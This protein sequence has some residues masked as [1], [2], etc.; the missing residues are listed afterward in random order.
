MDELLAPELVPAQ[1]AELVDT[2]SR[3]GDE[4]PD[5]ADLGQRLSFLA[6]T[7]VPDLLSAL[8]EDPD[9]LAFLLVTSVFEGLDHRLVRDETDRLLKLADG[10]LDA[11]FRPVDRDGDQGQGMRG[12]TPRPNPR[13]VF[14]RSLDELLETVRAEYLPSEVREAEGYTFTVEPVRFKRHR[15]AETVLRHVWRQYG[16]VSGLLTEWMD[17][18]PGTEPELARP[19][20]RVMGLAAGWSGGR[21][22]LRHIHEL[23]R[24][25]R[26]QSRRT[27]AYALGIAAQNEVLAGEV[28]YRLRSWSL[29]GG[30]RLRSTVA[31]ACGMDF[32]ASRPAFAISLLRHC[33]RGEEGDEQTVARAVE[34]ALTSLFAGGN[35]VAVFRHLME[36]ASRPG[37]DGE[38]AL[39]VFPHLLLDPSWFQQQLLTETEFTDAVIAFIRSALNDDGRY[40]RTSL[41]L[42]EWCHRALRD[43]TLQAAVES[44]LT[45]LA[46]GMRTGEFR[47]LVAV[48]GG[49]SE[50]VGRD[51][52]VWA[53]EAW[54]RGEPQPH[55]PAHTSEGLR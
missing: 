36:W 20:G 42:L 2:V 22:A 8:R 46:Q 34:W 7:E 32:G 18:V 25:D 23:A 52:A 19:V 31:D 5:L 30:W 12:E 49:G 33:H 13:F 37:R 55:Y 15:Q 26:A 45:V 1:V 53:L 41:V 50:I 17:D 35:Q 14:R 29:N 11:V 3:A 27:A 16:E 54:K 43:E 10:R 21:R 28:K 4:E 6:E 48:A 40:G 38:L 9:A 39:S 44:L 24:S 51:I 47:L